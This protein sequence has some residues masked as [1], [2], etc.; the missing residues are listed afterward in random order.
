MKNCKLC[1]NPIPP[2]R[3]KDSK[4]CNNSCKAKY[5]ELYGK[6]GKPLKSKPLS[7]LT[8]HSETF[9]TQVPPSPPLNPPNNPLLSGL[10]EVK[11]KEDQHLSPFKN[12]YPQDEPVS[13]TKKWTRK[14][15]GQASSS[16]LPSSSNKNAKTK[17]T[18]L[19][20]KYAFLEL[21]NK[22]LD[23]RL[24]EINTAI[25]AIQKEIRT[26]ENDP[27]LA[28]LVGGAVAGYGISILLLNTLTPKQKRKKASNTNAGT[29]SFSWGRFFTKLT[30]TAVGIFGG[31][32]LAQRCL[33]PEEISKAQVLDYYNGQLKE[34]L[35]LKMDLEKQKKTLNEKKLLLD[36]QEVEFEEIPNPELAIQMEGLPKME[37]ELSGISEADLD[38]FAKLPPQVQKAKAI[39]PDTLPHYDANS[40]IQKMKD[41]AGL[42]RPRLNFTGKWLDFFGIPQT[43]FFC[44]IHGMSGEGKT[45][46]AIQFAIYLAEMFG[47]V[48]YVSGEEG[49]NPTFQQKIKILGAD[50]VPSLYAAD[51]RTGEEIL[52]E[53]ESNFHFIF[54]DSVNNMDIDPELMKAIRAKFPQS[55]IIAICQSTKDGKMRGSY[56]LIHEADIAV[57]VVKGIALTTKNRFAES[58]RE[59]DVFEAY[60]KPRL[61]VIKN[62]KQGKNSGDGGLTFRNTI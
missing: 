5:F 3:R 46:F 15:F 17:N 58:M 7:G 37:T 22:R 21:D 40:K 26:T 4:F 62:N 42:K 14:P 31:F 6:T 36:A 12:L 45:N 23:K 56:E 59:F 18:L 29:E 61:T 44:V 33:E 43:N 35:T 24:I 53:V 39:S 34:K 52:T 10:N 49:F 27:S 9:Q 32:K 13:E 30:F 20:M 51:L 57:K 16:L 41:V 48:L 19:S 54:I 11:K 2:T 8:L 1:G 60:G 50:N 28:F 25:A 55:A 38:R 47:N